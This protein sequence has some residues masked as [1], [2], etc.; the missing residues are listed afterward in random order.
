MA[1]E[2]YQPDGIK[3]TVWPAAVAEKQAI[4]PMLPWSARK[5]EH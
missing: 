1:V 5:P 2:Q 3:Y 4:V